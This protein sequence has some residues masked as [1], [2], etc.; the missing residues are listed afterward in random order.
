[1]CVGEARWGEQKQNMREEQKEDTKIIDYHASMALASPEKVKAYEDKLD[2]DSASG[3]LSG[4]NLSKKKQKHEAVS[5]ALQWGMPEDGSFQDNED[6]IEDQ[7]KE[8]KD[9]AQE[10]V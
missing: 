3:S 1:M 7:A 2:R 4:H 8:K 6:V 9:K 10:E 5:E